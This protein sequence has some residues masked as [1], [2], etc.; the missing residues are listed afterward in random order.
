MKQDAGPRKRMHPWQTP[1]ALG[2]FF[3]GLL[4]V[5]QFRTQQREGFPLSSYRS[6]EL[7][8]MIRELEKERTNLRQ[9]LS[10]LRGQMAGYEKAALQGANLKKEL[11]SQM[12]TARLQAGLL[13]VKGPGLIVTLN[14]SPKRPKTGEDP[15]FFLVHDVDI[16][17]I[18]TELWAAGAE[19]VAVNDQRLVATTPIRC[20]GP[21]ILIN[22]VRLVPPYIITAIGDPSALETALKMR[23]GILDSLA[24]SILNGVEV[25]LEKR[26]EVLLSAYK[27]SL[28]FRYAKP[29]KEGED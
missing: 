3:L 25:R 28:L 6:S 24:P 20:V 27:G 17:Q 5:V 2:C 19:A 9:E 18:S 16:Q 1:L 26:K 29:V 15:Y 23:G 13:A 7:V 11:S 12:M 4:T 14:D 21:T 10:H 22:T 8:Q